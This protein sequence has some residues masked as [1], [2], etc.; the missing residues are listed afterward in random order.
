MWFAAEEA[1]LIATLLLQKAMGNSSESGFKPAVWPLVV[2][3]V[4]EAT[5][6]GV[7]KSLM[8]FKTCYHKVCA[9]YSIYLHVSADCL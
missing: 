7:R 3:V 5:S 2:N 1:A 6:E 9:Q 4:G 8:Q